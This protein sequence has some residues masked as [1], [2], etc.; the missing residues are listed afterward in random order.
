MNWLWNFLSLKT[1]CHTRSDMRAINGVRNRVATELSE[2]RP[3]GERY[4]HA[5]VGDD[6]TT[7]SVS[8]LKGRGGPP[9]VIWRVPKVVV[10][11]VDAASRRRFTHIPQKVLER[12]PAFAHPYTT[13]SI[14]LVV[15]AA[16]DHSAPDT[17]CARGSFARASTRR[18]PVCGA[19]AGRAFGVEATA[20]LRIPT[21]EVWSGYSHIFSAVAAAI[22]LR[23]SRFRTR[24][25][26][27]GETYKPVSN[28]VFSSRHVKFTPGVVC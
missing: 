18:V 5:A 23:V 2:F 1:E 13:S 17:V 6:P 15:P 12:V 26:G 20:R 19:P 10:D 24:E 25:G 9:A 28:H 7:S 16:R 14:A 4:A 22:P 27:N 3:G 11:P 8:A 21:Q